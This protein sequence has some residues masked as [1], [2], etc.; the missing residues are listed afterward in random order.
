MKKN[1]VNK[2]LYF[3]EDIAAWIDRTAIRLTRTAHGKSAIANEIFK[4]VQANITN[5]EYWWD[6]RGE[7]K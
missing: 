4:F 6:N 3:D 7:D 5:F 2:T 1:K